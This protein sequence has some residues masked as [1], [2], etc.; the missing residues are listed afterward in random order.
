MR[1]SVLFLCLM[2]MFATLTV[3][4][5]DAAPKKKSSTVRKATFKPKKVKNNLKNVD[6][7]VVKGG[8]DGPFFWEEGNGV[9]KYS[10]TPRNLV[11]AGVQVL[12]VRT[13]TSTQLEQQTVG[14]ETINDEDKSLSLAERQAKLN[15][16]IAADNK[17]RE[18]ENKRRMEEAKKSNCKAATLNLQ[19]AQTANRMQNRE[20]AIARYQNDVSKYCN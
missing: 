20:E 1:K 13:H 12:N 16:E 5:A 17:R 18:E 4:V 19:N 8:G 2:S 6:L 14:G 9:N 10:D 3:S 7:S 11:G 15:A